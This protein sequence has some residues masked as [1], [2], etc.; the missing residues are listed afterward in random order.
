MTETSTIEAPPLPPHLVARLEKAQRR[1]A[2]AEAKFAELQEDARR[3]PGRSDLGRATG[4]AALWRDHMAAELKGAHA[5]V[6]RWQQ[7]TPLAAARAALTAAQR[8]AD[9]LLAGA[10][11]PVNNSALADARIECERLTMLVR[12]LEDHEQLVA[13]DRAEVAGLAE[14]FSAE[15]GNARDRLSAA[16]APLADV[17]R[18]RHL[19]EVKPAVDDYNEALEQVIAEFTRMGL[20]HRGPGERGIGVARAQH[21]PYHTNTVW[22][23]ERP[24]IPVSAMPAIQWC[25]QQTLAEIGFVGSGFDLPFSRFNEVLMDAVNRGATPLRRAGRR[26][27]PQAA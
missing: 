12:R 7:L 9:A 16:L 22:L 14:R 11:S 10:I 13:A 25:A 4:D 5:V 1:L 17:M 20:V 27:G 26:P 21:S 18:E 19:L 2:D 3:T 6:K 15:I 24:W 23:D 8:K